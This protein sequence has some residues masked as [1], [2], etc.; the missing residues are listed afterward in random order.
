[1]VWIRTV[2]EAEAT[3]VVKEV[4]A[5]WRQRMDRND[6]ASDVVKVFSIAPRI[7][8]AVENLRTAIKD[9]ASSLGQDREEMIA[10]AVSSINRCTY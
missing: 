8:Q 2:P 5:H 3:G 4:Y 7:L 10:V 9:G 1:M 6:D